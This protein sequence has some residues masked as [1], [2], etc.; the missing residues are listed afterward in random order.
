MKFL[1]V[2]PR[3]HT[4]QIPV[5]DA[6]LNK[7]HTVV[8]LSQRAGYTEDYSLIKPYFLKKSFIWRFIEKI[9]DFKYPQNEAETYKINIFIPSLI[10]LYKL[11]KNY[12]PDVVILRNRNITSLISYMVCRLLGIK[13][14]LLYN[15]T[16]LYL[17]GT[18]S[19]SFK[20]KI[21]RKIFFPKVRITPVITDNIL[22]FNKN[23]KAYTNEEKTYFVPFIGFADNKILQRDYFLNS[24]INILSIGK[25]RDYKNHYL[26]VDAISLINNKEKLSVTIVGQACNK[27]EIDYYIQ[28]QKYISKLNL[29]NTIKLVK[30]IPFKDMKNIYLTNDI[31]VLASKH[32][33]ASISVIESM[34]YGL[35]TISSSSNGTASY[36]N[37]GECGFIFESENAEDLASKL[38]VIIKKKSLIPVMGRK[39]IENIHNNFMHDNYYDAIKR[40]LE[41]I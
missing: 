16:P 11:I 4:N 1:F 14:V 31:F 30:N 35:V 21:I 28:L 36:I 9:I 23:K 32:E 12:N 40:V 8:F 25:F 27:E 20:K 24:K 10:N 34:S 2:A 6:L 13:K 22:V 5:I 18:K 29:S 7:D 33:I 38:R 41:D 17:N 3:F 15:Q 19:M 37:N 39:A 26:L